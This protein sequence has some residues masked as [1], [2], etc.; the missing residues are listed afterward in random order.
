MGVHLKR[1]KY[2]LSVMEALR[3]SAKRGEVWLE[4]IEKPQ[5]ND[6]DD[7]LI[8]VAFAGLCGT[9]LHIV[10][11]EFKNVS[12]RDVTLSHEFSGR[13]VAL[14]GRAALRL[15]VGDKVGVDPN[16]PCHECQ[17]CVRGQ[18]NFCLE[19][20]P[21]DAVGI[22]RDGG[23][24]KYCKVPAEQVF[25]LPPSL[26]L[27]TG[28]LCEPLSC[29]L[30][31]WDRLVS[32]SPLQPDSR[33]LVTGA[34]IIGNLWATILHYHGARDVTI[35]EPSQG[36]RDITARLGT[37]YLITTPA[38]LSSLEEARHSE[39][40]GFDVVIECSGLPRALE[41]AIAWTKR[42]SCV[43]V[44]GCAPPG[45]AAKICPEEIFRKEITIVG[46]LINPHTYARA[47]QLAA[48]MEALYLGYE[49]LG[50]KVFPLSQY[51]EAIQQL[52]TGSIA[53]AVFN[54]K[55]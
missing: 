37:N 54:L 44:F 36:R 38:E 17:F 27:E 51:Q 16:R 49:K 11:G 43:M 20:G 23:M 4:R 19:G 6:P 46:S 52:K 5:I 9:D 24:A 14:G 32:R 10:S 28:A 1:S 50:V 18:V 26:E 8:E 30:H 31:G 35:S 47:V 25:V 48:S 22:F 3:C 41:Q 55:L 34:G 40:Q 29:I 45:A 33:V 2:C 42:G 53:K 12:E 21:R 7:V 39:T 13:V 15:K